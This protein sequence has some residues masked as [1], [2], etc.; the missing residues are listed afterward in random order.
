MTN[1]I[2]LGIPPKNGRCTSTPL[3]GIA[4][5]TNFNFTQYGWED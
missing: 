1:R 2:Y 5:V 4:N 3:F